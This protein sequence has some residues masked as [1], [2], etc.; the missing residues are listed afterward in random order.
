MRLVTWFSP[1][2]TRLL[3]VW[4]LMLPHLVCS[5][6]Q[7]VVSSIARY[8][9]LLSLTHDNMKV[10]VC[11]LLSLKVHQAANFGTKSNMP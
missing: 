2:T 5:M 10:C 1:Q 4:K 11:I 8:T 7:Y 9:M 3:P 6:S